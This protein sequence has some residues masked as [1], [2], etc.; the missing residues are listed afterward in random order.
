MWQA[1]PVNTRWLARNTGSCVDGNFCTKTFVVQCARVKDFCCAVYAIPQR[2]SFVVVLPYKNFCWLMY[3]RHYSW[4]LDYESMIQY[5]CIIPIKLF[6]YWNRCFH[7]YQHSDVRDLIFSQFSI[8]C[9]QKCVG[10]RGSAP[11]PDG[12]FTAPPKPRAGQSWV[13][14]RSCPDQRPCFHIHLPLATPLFSVL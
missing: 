9:C 1:R 7:V 11:F 4:N 2:L 3:T 5:F 10:F 14:N 6:N 8:D 13:T 12:G